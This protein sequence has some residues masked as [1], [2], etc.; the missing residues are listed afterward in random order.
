MFDGLGAA[1]AASLENPDRSVDE[2]VRELRGSQRQVAEYLA[3]EVLAGLE[4]ERREHLM[5]ISILDA[6][7]APLCA[8]ITGEDRPFD[9][10]ALE[11]ER[12]PIQRLDGDGHRLRFQAEQPLSQAVQP[13][14][15][16]S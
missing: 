4:P 7:C 12:L 6:F 16:F 1:A 14:P 8:A 2:L 5:R 10:D 11:S 3:E 9:F 13:S 15:R